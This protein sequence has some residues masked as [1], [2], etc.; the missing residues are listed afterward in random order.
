MMSGPGSGE[1]WAIE[2]LGITK[3]FSRRPVL[4][5]LHLKVA[6]GSFLTI[7]GANGSGKT[8]L[9]KLLSTIARPET[10]SI[11][12]AG[13]DTREN[14]TQVRRH[15]GVILHQTL[16]YDD[17]TVQENLRFYGRMFDVP[18]L[19]ERIAFVAHRGG[20]NSRLLHPVRTLSRGL[21][22]RAAICRALLHDPAILLLDEPETGL[23]R[24]AS[25]AFWNT[26]ASLKEEGK[27][28]VMT[29]HNMEWG[30]NLGDQVAILA[31]GRIA[32]QEDKATLSRATFDGIY[33]RYTEVSP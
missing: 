18:R 9:I 30:L 3:S 1:A 26:L 13:M 15:L 2:A 4:R 25:L 19:E 8:T 16:L 24:H 22:Q 27:T 33:H 12:I 31:E 23:D 7:F 28:I 14:A 29:T 20:L 10:G 17:L 5:N 21:Q 32:Y 6:E 11:V